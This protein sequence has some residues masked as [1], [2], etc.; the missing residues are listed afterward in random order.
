MKPLRTSPPPFARARHVA[1][2]AAICVVA[3]AVA[4]GVAA[5]PKPTL[6]KPARVFDGTRTHEGWAVLVEGERVTAVGPLGE[7]ERQ[8]VLSIELPGATV[9]PGLIEGH[10]HL[11]LHPYNEAS[12]DEQVLK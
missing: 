6:L 8:N 10:S 3:I 1:R 9:L 12:W 4:R 7:L 2:V 5:Q 11:L